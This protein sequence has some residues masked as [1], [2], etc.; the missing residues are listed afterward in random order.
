MNTSVLGDRILHKSNLVVIIEDTNNNKFG[1]FVSKT[2]NQ[3]DAWIN[4]PNAFVFSLRSNGRINGMMK[5]NITQSQYAFN[6]PSRSNP[7]LFS[8]GSGMDICVSKIRGT[9]NY[10]SRGSFDYHGLT[11]A[12]CGGNNFTPK[13][14]TVIKMK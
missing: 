2:I 9:G 5:F 11:N 1:G 4:D 7:G 6:L 13:R 14:I 12:L 3:Y 8:M 10:C